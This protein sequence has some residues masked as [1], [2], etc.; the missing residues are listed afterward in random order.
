MVRC[1]RAARENS[2]MGGGIAKITLFRDDGSLCLFSLV[3][4]A[5]T[6]V[7]DHLAWWASI[8]AAKR[9]FMSVSTMAIRTR[10]ESRDAPD[11]RSRRVLRCCRRPTHSC[12][13]G[14]R[15]GVNLDP[16]SRTTPRV[17]G[18]IDSIPRPARSRRFGLATRTRPVHRINRPAD[19]PEPRPPS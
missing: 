15:D 6:P 1:V 2:R 14:V 3:V 11:A 19:P 4:P 13:D 17:S 5:G 9:R 8:A 16:I 18:G 10:S 7:H 12:S